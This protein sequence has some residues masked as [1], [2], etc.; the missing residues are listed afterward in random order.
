MNAMDAAMMTT[1]PSSLYRWWPLV[2]WSLALVAY[3]VLLPDAGAQHWLAMILWAG[4][5]LL[6]GIECLRAA[7]ITPVSA[8][9]WRL[10]GIA[11]LCR[12]AAYFHWEIK[13]NFPQLP[14]WILH[15]TVGQLAYFVYAALV[16]K[17][18]R[19]MPESNAP[20]RF[21]RRHAGNLGLIACCF[22]ATVAITLLEPA[23]SSDL[24]RA[25]VW[26]ALLDAVVAV[27]MFFAALYYLWSYR[28]SASWMPMLLL[29]VGTGAY[30][31]G[32]FIYAPAMLAGNANL[33][34]LASATWVGTFVLFAQAARERRHALTVWDA[35]R[36]ALRFDREQWL[37]AV[38][39]AL[40]IIMM[41]LVAIVSREQLT[42]RVVV[43]VTPIIILFAI[44]L[45]V[46]EAWIQGESQRLTHDLMEANEKL[47]QANAKLLEGEIRYRELNQQ[48]EQRVVERTSQLRAAYQEL[49][50]FAYAVAHDL[51]APLR[52]IDGFGHL[53]EQELAGQHR[54]ATDGYLQRIRR[55]A[56]K[57]S[58]LIDDLLAYSRLERK[59]LEYAAVELV[60]LIHEMLDE[61][62]LE[63]HSRRIDVRLLVQPV[64][65]QAD[66]EG[67]KVALRNLIENAIKF[68][69]GIGSPRLEIAT[70][71]DGGKV[72]VSVSDNGIGF[73]MCYHDQIW[74]LFQRL[75]RETD[76]P[77]TGT[78]LALVRKAMARMGG[79]AWAQSQEGQG[80]TFFLEF[81]GDSV[82]V[83]DSGV[84]AEA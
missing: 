9:A 46:R 78:G 27:G 68:T 26:L 14:E 29:V 24:P 44:I 1:T 72:T 54:S 25:T 28:W 12:F 32:N 13:R 31:V 69:R 23:I 76:F 36:A 39:P 79:R 5:P 17:A 64:T 37:E 42:A 50:G 18:L 2:V 49:E 77:G 38:I 57:M 80:A 19:A 55:N 81:G 45:G 52:A 63:I 30:S 33:T 3:S 59:G 11:C 56:L 15:L 40:L 67:I 22:A 74:K 7:R 70:H 73:D 84:R 43:T 82:V 75:H 51:K 47:R 16:F 58:H 53:L 21:T 41:V 10:L 48:L 62:A 6:A 71:V 20:A 60:P 4:A 66:A 65:L 34:A 8:R 61:H 83:E 35:R